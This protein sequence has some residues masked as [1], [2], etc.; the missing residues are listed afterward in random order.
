MKKNTTTNRTKTT[1]NGKKETKYNIKKVLWKPV[2]NLKQILYLHNNYMHQHKGLSLLALD[3]KNRLVNMIH[4]GY[5]R[6]KLL[7]FIYKLKLQ[8]SELILYYH[9]EIR[10]QI[11]GTMVRTAAKI[12]GKFSDTGLKIRDFILFTRKDMCSLR[13]HY[14]N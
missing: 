7:P 8:T 13:L 10:E 14:G 3:K 9:H 12:R 6:K 4:V 2:T 11:S 5:K 1:L